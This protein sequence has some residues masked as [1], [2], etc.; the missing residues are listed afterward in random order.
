M[1]S[2]IDPFSDRP[3]GM[4]RGVKMT[5]VRVTPAPAQSKP[6]TRT[7]TMSLPEQ[8]QAA[9][10]PTNLK[11]LRLRASQAYISERRPA[12]IVSPPRVL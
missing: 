3:C 2:M 6:L 10:S 12:V 9:T 11:S 8:T 1:A 5:S 4:S 7:V